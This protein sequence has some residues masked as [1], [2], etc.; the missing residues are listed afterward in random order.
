MRSDNPDSSA[1]EPL[2]TEPATMSANV[3]R[4]I[5]NTHASTRRCRP[6]RLAMSTLLPQQESDIATL[7][8]AILAAAMR[9][10]LRF[11]VDD[12]RLRVEQDFHG[13][14]VFADECHLVDD[15]RLRVE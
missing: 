3:A 10:L 7:V 15:H 6:C 11:P 8:A 13:V 5:P 2:S 4:L 14:R 12:H 1:E 9:H